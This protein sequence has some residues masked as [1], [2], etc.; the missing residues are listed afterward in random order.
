MFRFQ[1]RQLHMIVR[2]F[3]LVSVVLFFIM[4]FPE[5]KQFD[6]PQFEQMIDYSEGWICNYK[7]SDVETLK[8]HYTEDEIMSG[9]NRIEDVRS[10]PFSLRVKKGET[11]EMTNKIPAIAGNNGYL[12]FETDRQK[13]EVYAG[14]KFLYRSS[15]RDNKI[16]ALH[17]VKVSKVYEG[18][19]LRIIVKDKELE[20]VSF[21]TFQFGSDSQLIVSSLLDNGAYFICG[22]GILLLNVCVLILFAIIKTQKERRELLVSACA[23]AFI[24]GMVLILQSKLFWVLTGWNYSL[25]FA[26]ACMILLLGVS[27]LLVI[28]SCLSRKKVCFFVDLG[29]VFYG[30][31]YISVMVLQA[32]SLI[33]FTTIFII[34]VILLIM[35][36]LLY[37]MLLSGL[38]GKPGRNA[39]IY[40]LVGNVF[41]I[42]ALIGHVLVKILDQS[43]AE[44]LY[45]PLA[46]F[47]YMC[48]IWFKGMKQAAYVKTEDTTEY[49]RNKIRNEVVEEMN[50]N[51]LFASFHVLQNMIKKNSPNSVKMIY[52][53]SEYFRDNLRA[54]EQAGEIVPFEQELEHILAYLQLQKHRNQELN[55][56]IE[57]KE[58][59]FVIPRHTIEP[60]VENAVKYGIGGSQNKGNVVVRSY[61]RTDGYALQIVDDGI[62]FDTAGLKRKS[63]TSLLNLFD[64]L[65]TKCGARTE[66]ISKEGKGTVITIVM[67]ILD[68]DLLKEE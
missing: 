40:L 50:P 14:D 10:L 29:I 68:N 6:K 49:E 5:K 27:H 7:V 54:L 12:V 36:I 60:M 48:V 66:I 47:L 3:F 8:E 53:I 37:T 64:T 22:I 34:G 45:I 57:C 39:L 17:V 2:L 56:A 30:I 31:I 61:Q 20:Q 18:S 9:K 15:E 59:N 11:F 41:L 43:R 21:G 51:L 58:K 13:V 16:K 33:Q 26:K 35:V 55:F 38:I 52:Y 65:K 32:F 62:G 19:N 25:Y 1:E 63:Q 44:Q 67:P 24:L 46:W 4:A 23:Q 42:I 28:R